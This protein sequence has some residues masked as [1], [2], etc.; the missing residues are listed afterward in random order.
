MNATAVLTAVLAVLFTAIGVAKLAAVPSMR[1]RAAHVGLSVAAY[2]VIGALEVAGAVGLVAG[3][4]V[5]VL[6]MLAALGLVLLLVGAVV[7]HLRAR[8]G[9]KEMVPAIVLGG[10]SAGLLALSLGAFG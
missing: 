3:T 9:L 7:A 4:V 5:P 8:D 2:R 6:R 1:T 10:L